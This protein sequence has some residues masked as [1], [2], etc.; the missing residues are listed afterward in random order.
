MLFSSFFLFFQFVKRNDL[1]RKEEPV[2]APC[3][4]CLSPAS[5]L[6]LLAWVNLLVGVGLGCFLVDLFFFMDIVLL[7][8]VTILFLVF[9]LIA[10]TSLLSRLGCCVLVGVSFSSR[11]SWIGG[12][13]NSPFMQLSASLECGLPWLTSS[14]FLDLWMNSSV[15]GESEVV[16]LCDLSS[17]M[18][19]SS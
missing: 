1:K 4:E 16:S 8:L 9:L 5:L 10:F 17:S 18:N 6:L 19:Y 15:S 7:F 2:N 12:S 3:F 13:M 11:A 14:L